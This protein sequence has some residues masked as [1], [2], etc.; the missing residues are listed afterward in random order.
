[1]RCIEPTSDHGS[2]VIKTWSFSITQRQKKR[3]DK[4]LYHCVCNSWAFLFYKAGVRRPSSAQVVVL[5]VYAAV[6]ICKRLPILT[7][8]EKKTGLKARLEK[9][10]Q[11]W[12]TYFPLTKLFLGLACLITKTATLFHGGGSRQRGRS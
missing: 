4:K 1:M 3:R 7:V 9:V 5:G 2:V 12:Q 8:P 11:L 10:M 6:F